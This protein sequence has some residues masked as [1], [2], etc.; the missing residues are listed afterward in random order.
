M[1]K[2]S[3]YL[4][5]QPS[6]SCTLGGA[7]SISVGCVRPLNHKQK[8]EEPQSCGLFGLSV[9]LRNPSAVVVAMCS[10]QGLR[11]F[12]VHRLT[13][14][15]AQILPVL[16]HAIVQNQEKID[17]QRRVLRLIRKPQTKVYTTGR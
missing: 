12:T 2:I 9:T 16:E 1:N 8:E 6:P 7:V 4:S 13:T 10:L 17:A 5:I 15:A 14:A 3:I 11:E